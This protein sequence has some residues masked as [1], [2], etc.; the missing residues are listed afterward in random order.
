MENT[1]DKK[2]KVLSITE[3]AKQHN[4]TRQ[5]IYVAIKEKKLRAEK[6]NG[7]WTISTDALR[8][9]KEQKY[10]REKS[11]YNG[12]LLFDKQKGTYSVAQV[13]KML[14]VPVQTIYY[15]LRSGKLKGDQTGP[16]SATWIISIDNV[17]DYQVNYLAKKQNKKKAG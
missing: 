8:D 4:V 16:S 14:N 3:A 1:M 15:A 17:T 13:S 11:T 6:I 2:K 7:R 9:Y 10:S 12:E 5:A